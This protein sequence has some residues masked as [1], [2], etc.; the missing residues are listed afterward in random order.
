M[1]KRW[2]AGEPDSPARGEASPRHEVPA[3]R[4]KQEGWLNGGQPQQG[5]ADDR[6]MTDD[7]EPG[8]VVLE[9]KSTFALTFALLRAPSP[10]RS[11]GT[12]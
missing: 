2:F 12:F 7:G 1:C 11:R 6:P 10:R 4:V 5:D 8:Q 9:H 3:E